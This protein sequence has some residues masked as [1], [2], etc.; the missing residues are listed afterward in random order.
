MTNLANA[1][2]PHFDAVVRKCV[3]VCVC[4]CMNPPRQL[5][6]VVTVVVVGSAWSASCVDYNCG[7]RY[8]PFR[9]FLYKLKLLP[10]TLQLADVFMSQK[11]QRLS[12]VG[13]LYS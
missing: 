8:T 1:I 12:T 3:R 13:F 11:R 5:R 7:Q 4:E 10:K 2:G 6:L 9:H